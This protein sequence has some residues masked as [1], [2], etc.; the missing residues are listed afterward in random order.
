MAIL[1]MNKLFNLAELLRNLWEFI[2]PVHMCFV[3]LEKTYDCVK[4]E[5]LQAVLWE[6]GT[7]GP[8]S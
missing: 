8:L 4:R 6:Y 5:V 3:D 7:L 1:A 2:Q